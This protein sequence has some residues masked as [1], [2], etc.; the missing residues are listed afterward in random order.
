M[1][2]E[3]TGL[4]RLGRWPAPNICAACGNDRD[5]SRGYPG[6]VWYC[7]PC[8][9]AEPGDVPPAAVTALPASM[10]PIAATTAVD[11]FSGF[12]PA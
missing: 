10:A 3:L 4:G 8:V 11:L 6:D 9:P 5:A 7:A 2:V 12:T 1:A